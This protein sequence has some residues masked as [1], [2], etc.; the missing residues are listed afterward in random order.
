[1]LL[2]RLVDRAAVDDAVVGQQRHAQ[3]VDVAVLERAGLGSRRSGRRRAQRLV[4]GHRAPRRR[5]GGSGAGWWRASASRAWLLRGDAAPATAGRAPRPTKRETLRGPRG[6]VVGGRGQ[7][8]LVLGPRHRHVE[9]PPLL[10]QVGVRRRQASPSTRPSGSGSGSRRAA[11]PGTSARRS[12]PGT[13]PGTRGPWPCARSGRGRRPRRGRP[14]PPPGRRP[15]RAAGRGGSTNGG[16]A[17]V[18]GHVAVG[19]HGL[20]EAG[21]VLDPRLGLGASPRARAAPAGPTPA[22]TCRAPRRCAAA[23]RR[24]PRG[25]GRR[26]A[27]P[28]PR[29]P[30]RRRRPA[31]RSSGRPRST[32]SSGRDLRRAYWLRR[33]RSVSGMRYS[34]EAAR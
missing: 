20:E 10:V 6:A 24:R 15:P 14:R 27:A 2:H 18:L 23:A 5:G 31:P 4:F 1:M 33:S 12:R 30:R 9:E 34:S 13:P 29:A 25:R 7:D 3:D 17:V 16:H 28:P 21:D 8:Q 32:S 26:A 19:L 22:G 11:A